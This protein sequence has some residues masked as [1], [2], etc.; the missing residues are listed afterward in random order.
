[1]Y[2]QVILY[3]KSEKIISKE[4][5]KQNL[6]FKLFDPFFSLKEISIAK[7]KKKLNPETYFTRK[8]IRKGFSLFLQY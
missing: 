3:A 1:M 4:L 8:E 7:E 5:F 2:K 6:I